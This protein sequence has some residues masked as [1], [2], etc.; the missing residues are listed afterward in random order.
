LPFRSHTKTSN[1]KHPA[2]T[3]PGIPN[4]NKRNKSPPHP[5]PPEI[6]SPDPTHPDAKNFPATN[7]Q[8][9]SK[10]PKPPLPA[11]TNREKILS[12][13]TL[14]AIPPQP[15]SKAEKSGTQ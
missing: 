3:I 5:P 8:T 15:A 14:P 7:P 11:R 10:A 6:Q 13:D 2:Q 1:R 4:R 9:S 12:P